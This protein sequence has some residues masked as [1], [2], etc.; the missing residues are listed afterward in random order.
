MKKNLYLT[1]FCLLL[2]T[3]YSKAQTLFSFELPTTYNATTKAYELAGVGSFFRGTAGGSTSFGSA[4]CD[5]ID[6]SVSTSGNTFIFLAVGDISAIT[7]RGNGTGSNRTLTSVSTSSTLT[8]TYSTI[9]APGVGTINGSTCGTIAI[10]P[11]TIIPGGTYIKF[12]FSGNLN[13]T[14]LLLT[15]TASVA[16]TVTTNVPVAT[17]VTSSSAILGGEVTNAGSSSITVSGIAY[18]ISADPTIAGTKTTDGPTGTG[19]IASPVTGL[20]FSTTYHARAYATSSAGTSYGADQTFTTDAPSLPTIIT[21]PGSLN[22]GSL[23]INTTSANKTF[24]IVAG[25]L[26]PA[27][28]NISVTAPA[29]YEISNDA[30]SGFGSSVNVAYNSG[31]LTSTTLYVRFIPTALVA[32]NGSIVLEG[33]GATQSLAVSGNGSNVSYT[34]GDYGS[35]TSGNWGTTSTWKLWD[36]NGFN[37]VAAAAPTTADNVWINV[38]DTVIVEAS[39]K[40]CKNLYVNG[41]IRSNSRV[42][43]PVYIRVYGTE[44][45]VAPGALMG[46]A[47]QT[48]GDAADGLSI[49]YFGTVSNPTNP[50]VTITGGGTIGISRLRTNTS[51]TTVVIDNDMTLNYH[52][53]SN[54]GNA[55]GY[56]TAAGD[57]NT[58]TINA[59][60]TLTFAPWSC[61]TPVSS[62]HTNGG[63]TGGTMDI[64]INGTM[65]FMPGN[66]APDT[67]TISRILWHPSGY[68]SLG[69]S[70]NRIV[71]LNIGSVGVLNVTEF[72]PNGTKAD[73]TPGTG[74]LIS[75]NVAG[76]G[77][78]NVSK[79][80]DFRNPLQTVT[81]A[82]TFNLLSGAKLRIGSVDGITA[83]SAAGNIQTDVRNFSNGAA[84]AYEGVV[85]QL[86]GDGLPSTVSGLTV[87]NADSLILS[88][89]SQTTDSL[90]LISGIII[91]EAAK[92]LTVGTASV[93]NGGS[94]ASHVAGPVTRLTNSIDNYV[95]PVG[96]GGIYHPATITPSTATASS[97]T[98]EYFNVSGPL[99]TSV[100]TPITSVGTSEY[101]DITKNSGSDARLWL[102]YDNTLTTTWSNGGSPTVAHEIVVAHLV[103]GSWIDETGAGGTSISGSAS[104]GVTISQIMSTFSPFTFGLRPAGTVPVS[105]ISFNATLVNGQTKLYWSTNNEI[106]VAKYLV[107]KSIDGKNF[108]ATENIILASNLISNTYS[109]TD[110]DLIV[111]VNY[112]RLKIIDRNGGSKYSNIIAVNNKA[113]NALAVFPNPVANNLYVSHSK[114]LDG[115]KLEVYGID[116]RKITEYKV[117]KDAVQSTVN[118]TGLAKGNYNLVLVNGEKIQYIQFVKQ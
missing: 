110:Q 118:A 80:A 71:N 67:V 93:V 9:T 52:G 6:S 98:G 28:G 31:S 50:I 91:T 39:S 7:V 11:E 13:I 74:T 14:S 36:G 65:T 49:D 27:G 116:G 102:S 17:S 103:S 55:A 87:N 47:S 106:N 54:A 82:G 76:G 58:L 51:H 105:L 86:S 70:G 63:S 78:L 92:M 57:S 29:G 30:N 25:G 108:N 83:T 26:S 73:N 32:Y 112:Y 75:I 89:S 56:Y 45:N 46:S 59:G 85:N 33:G 1:I 44:V 15:A 2:I 100:T 60:K 21:D 34:I 90:N 20:T 97:Y 42:N 53:S 96:K 95:F 101:W 10:T 77:A 69:T 115:A 4:V 24:T 117:T 12:I 104:S 19:A 68:M 8:G 16:P 18:G 99:T 111:G 3:T 61:Y 38:A 107:E 88:A 81:G 23:L 48:L 114:A 84:Y 66:A 5:G 79:I 22:F 94:I 37:T 109:V 43:S 41:R 62:S 35:V 64:N 72:Y 113:K 40:N